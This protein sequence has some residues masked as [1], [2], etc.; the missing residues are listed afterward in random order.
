MQLVFIILALIALLIAGVA[1]VIMLGRGDDYIVG[2][3]IA[4]SNSRDMYDTKRLRIVV[5]V[6]LL[7][8]AAALPIFAA[9]LIMGH[10]AL[11]MIAFPALA[12]ILIAG[13]F[14]VMHFWVKKKDKK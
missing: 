12:F 7:L 1:I 6:L 2:Y 3:N 13:T 14:T 5:G 8:I 10:I 11:V 9:L 4:S